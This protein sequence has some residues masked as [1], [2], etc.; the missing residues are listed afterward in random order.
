MT[1][2]KAV[3]APQIADFIQ[4]GYPCLFLPTVEPQ[5]AEQRVKDALSELDMVDVKFGVWKV[6]TGLMTGHLDTE[7][8]NRTQEARDLTQ[9]LTKIQ[10]EAE[11]EKNSRTYRPTVIIFHN[12]RQFINHA[13]VIQAFIDAVHAVRLRGSHIVLVGAHLELPPELRSL[14]TFV[15]CPLP[16]RKQIVKL[17]DKMIKAYEADIELPEDKEEKDELILN[18]ANAA[19]GLDMMGAENAIALS[20]ATAETIHLPII[21]KQKQQEVRKSDVLEFFDVRDSMDDVGGFDVMKSWMV[22]RKRVFTEE[23]RAYGL[24]YPKGVLIV[25]PAGTGKSLTAKATA[26]YLGLPLLR[27]DMGKIYRGI[28]GEAEAAARMSLAVAEA[29]SP[30]VLWLDEIDKGFAGMQ[31]SGN[32]DSGVSARVVGTILTWRQET[33]YPVMLVCTANEV[34]N[35]PSMVYRKGRLDEVWATDLPFEHERKEIF[36]IHLIKRKRD[37][38]DFDIDLLAAKTDSWTGA[39]IEGSI[40][41]AMFSAFDDDEEVDT[42][43]ILKSIKTTIPQAKRSAEEIESIRD[44]VKTR[45]RLVSSELIV[46]KRSRGSK[47]R[48][49]H[50]KK[51]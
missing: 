28:V 19:L 48:K 8:V 17:Y 1:N 21:A 42:S 49:I 31:S 24:P 22:R 12:L 23:A 40:E 14:V 13:N 41:D 9:A 26:S 46:K 30:V 29:V 43:Y 18:A 33:T 44:W 5:V 34:S 37:P 45:A 38:E 39:E 7:P 10:E 47:V 16:T 32:L 11:D 50:S 27:L 36:S 2:P 6:S 4:A 35:I 51:K 25:G 15:D 3:E 20:M